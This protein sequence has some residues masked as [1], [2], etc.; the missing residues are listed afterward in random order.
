MIHGA[1]SLETSVSM[2]ACS[3]IGVTHT[4]I[5]EELHSNAI[6]KR[7]ELLK[8]EIIITRTKNAEILKFFK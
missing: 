8:P 4:V 6:L 2:L 3:K 7:I 1:A 5:F